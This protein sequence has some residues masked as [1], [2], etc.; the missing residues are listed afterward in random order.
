WWGKDT[1]RPLIMA[2]QQKFMEKMQPNDPDLYWW[3]CTNFLGDDF[4]EC[5]IDGKHPNDL[6]TT[7]M[8]DAMIKL[9]APLFQK[10]NVFK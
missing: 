3:D 7:R 2:E 5:H 1:S 9:L 8:A 6:G 10:Y 4:G